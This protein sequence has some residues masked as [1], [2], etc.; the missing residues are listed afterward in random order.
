[1]NCYVD[2]KTQLEFVLMVGG[3][4]WASKFFSSSAANVCVADYAAN[5]R[6]NTYRKTLMIKGHKSIYTIDNGETIRNCIVLYLHILLLWVSWDH[7]R[8]FF[9]MAI[10]KIR[11]LVS[12]WGG[13]THFGKTPLKWCIFRHDFFCSQFQIE[14]LRCRFKKWSMIHLAAGPH[15]VVSEVT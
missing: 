1:M 13:K 8:C 7:Q 10:L 12:F 15:V 9:K 4:S 14:D 3:L 11:E 6:L 2:S 5:L